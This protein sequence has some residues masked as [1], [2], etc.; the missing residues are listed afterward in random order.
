MSHHDAYPNNPGAYNRL[1]SNL[2]QLHLGVN[3]IDNQIYAQSNRLLPI[4]LVEPDRLADPAFQEVL[5]IYDWPNLTDDG[6]IETAKEYANAREFL[7]SIPRVHEFGP[8]SLSSMHM[9]NLFA[10]RPIRRYEDSNGY[11][12]AA[13]GVM[14]ALH[15]AHALAPDLMEPLQEVLFELYQQSRAARD[16]DDDD[17]KLMQLLL[18]PNNA[19]VVEAMYMAYRITGS[20]FKVDDNDRINEVTGTK[21]INI[22]PPIISADEAL[23]FAD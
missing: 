23:R 10:H 9:F 20:L 15:R 7:Q 19:D 18:E 6:I 22:R 17:D 3:N 13:N 12:L 11:V 4:E 21:P 14:P 8:A 1:A 5:G 2:E 16:S